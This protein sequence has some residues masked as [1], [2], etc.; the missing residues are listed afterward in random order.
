MVERTLSWQNRYRWLKA[1]YERRDD[2]H[3]AF[4]RPR[5]RD[6][7]LAPGSAILLGA[8]IARAFVCSSSTPSASVR[9]L[10]CTVGDDG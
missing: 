8:F 1:R 6:D 9:P 5:L 7:L 4:S 2:I 10:C 3:Q